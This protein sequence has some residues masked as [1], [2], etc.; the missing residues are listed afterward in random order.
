MGNQGGHRVRQ[1][2]D[3]LEEDNLEEDNLEEDNL[4]EEAQPACM[5]Q[6]F[7]DNQTLYMYV[8][9]I[10]ETDV[11]LYEPRTAMGLGKIKSGN[12]LQCSHLTQNF[13]NRFLTETFCSAAT[14]L[15]ACPRLWKLRSAACLSILLKLRRM[16]KQAAVLSFSTESAH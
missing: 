16:L 10:N 1:E 11:Q 5:L 8:W 7:R 9:R 2:E 15:V 14:L 13:R 3:S 12:V 6:A 4:E